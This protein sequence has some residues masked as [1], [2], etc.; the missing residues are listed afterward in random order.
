MPEEVIKRVNRMAQKTCAGLHFAN[1]HNNANLDDSDT[2]N[3]D[4]TDDDYV[5]PD[6]REEYDINHKSS[7]SS[8]DDEADHTDNNHID[9]DDDV[10]IPGVPDAPD[11]DLNITGVNEPPDANDK[12][13]S[14]D[15]TLNDEENDAESNSENSN[16]D[17]GELKL[18]WW[19]WQWYPP[20]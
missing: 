12:L 9:H 13:A 19:G 17:D 20:L 1:W 15:D 4:S 8:S 3:D 18:R 7:D 10:P 16:S 14:N 2:D 5:P 11:Y 6:T